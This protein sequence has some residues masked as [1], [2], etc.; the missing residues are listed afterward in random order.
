M[1]YKLESK[2]L[3]KL[4]LANVL[5]K[6]NDHEV[7]FHEI[8]IQLF[9]EI[10][11]LIMRSKFNLFMRSNLFINIWQFWSGGQIFDHEIEIQKS[12]IRNFDL[13]IILAANKLIMRSKFK[14]SI[15][16]GFWSHE[17]CCDQE[18]EFWPHEKWEKFDLMNSI[19]LK[20]EF[21][22]H[23]IWPPDPQSCIISDCNFEN[24]L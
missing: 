22:S 12:I 16:R 11:F 3:Y 20:N 2:T 4:V 8:K 5:Q 15:I 19:S 14:K 24:S 9:H 1:K 17:K 13:M 10:E 23:E 7:K 6:G 21:R 18:I